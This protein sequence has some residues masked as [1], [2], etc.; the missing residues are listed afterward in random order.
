MEYKYNE[1]EYGKYIY[2]NGFYTRF[3]S[4]ELTVLVKYLKSIG[5]NKKETEQFLYKFCK[6]HIEGFNKVKYYKTIDKSI[7]DGRKKPFIVVK[8]IPIL[9]KELE[10]IQ[11]L[12]LD[13]EYKKLLLALLVNRKIAYEINKINN[14]DN[15]HISTYFNGTKK[16]FREVFKS[17][18]ITKKG[19]KIDDMINFLVQNNVI[20]SIIKGDIVLSYMCDIYDTEEDNDKKIIYQ[21][22]NDGVFVEISDFENI[23]YVFEY[24]LGNKKIKMCEVEKCNVLFKKKSNNQKYCAECFKKKRKNDI[25]KNAKEYYY[26]N[27]NK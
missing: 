8:N 19:Y 6:Q 18:N 7:L 20:E 17:A 11:N 13:D 9:L 10:S 27:K 12:D 5:K 26:D 22:S 3:I 2:E 15:A 24:Y 1:Q 25:N 4:Y 16:R 14:G 21:Y 23:G